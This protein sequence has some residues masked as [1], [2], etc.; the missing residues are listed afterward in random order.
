MINKYK[1]TF[2]TKIFAKVFYLYLE[3]DSLMAKIHFLGN[4]NM[5]KIPGFTGIFDVKT[6]ILIILNLTLYKK[7]K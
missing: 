1:N 3:F 5:Q 2:T 4:I 7:K 6:L